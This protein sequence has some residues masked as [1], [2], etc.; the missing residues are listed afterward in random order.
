MRAQ[1]QNDYPQGGGGQRYDQ[2]IGLASDGLSYLSGQQGQAQ[3]QAQNAN[4]V[5]FNSEPS[6]VPLN[7]NT[8]SLSNKR[9]APNGNGD[10]K[11]PKCLGCGAIETPEWRRGPMG[12]RTLCNACVSS[13]LDS[14][15]LK[16]M[17]RD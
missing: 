10:K 14:V 12:P 13:L 2:L 15:R 9:S 6:S 16:L 3:A 7:A 4:S 8:P 11:T 17:D 5:P 1:A